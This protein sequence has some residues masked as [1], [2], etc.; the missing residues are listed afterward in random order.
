MD[1]LWHEIFAHSTR[2]DIP[3]PL[4]VIPE[5]SMLVYLPVHGHFLDEVIAPWWQGNIADSQ[6][7]AWMA[8]AGEW[9]AILH[10]HP[11]ALEKYFQLTT[12]LENLA[13]WAALVNQSYP[14]TAPATA[15]ILEYLQAW[16]AR[17]RFS[18]QT[19]IHKDFHYRHVIVNRVSG[20]LTA[21]DFDEMR[22]GD[23][24]FDLAHFC[25][26]LHLLSYRQTSSLQQGPHQVARLNR[27][28]LDAY[29]SRTGWVKDERFRYFSLYTR[30]K[31]AKQLCTGRGPH[32]RPAGEEQRRQVH[33][34]LEDGENGE[35]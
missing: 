12:E 19:P 9:L 31:I 16:A 15:R 21:I 28:F 20:D 10:Q 27:A 5:L 35:W 1:C 13:A 7:A 8:L 23:P 11:F 18:T 14:E 30:L 25:L 22:L 32:P 2:L 6:A 26:N 3:R 17:L 33:R 34:I 29:A 4:G 24:A